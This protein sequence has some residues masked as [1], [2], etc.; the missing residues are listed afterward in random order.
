MTRCSDS[1]HL[2]VQRDLG[3]QL[4]TPVE[5]HYTFSVR[6]LGT[7][8]I[9]VTGSSG[10]IG[11]AVAEHFLSRGSSVIGI[12]SDARSDFFGDA[13]STTHNTQRLLSQW[14]RFTHIPVDI[15]DYAS[16]QAVVDFWRPCAVI[17]SA[18]QPSHDL[19]AR[20][21]FVDFDINAR[22]TLN[23]LETARRFVPESPFIFLSTNKV[24]GTKPNDLPFVEEETRWEFADSHL[25]RG[26]DE[27]LGL[28]Q[29][30]HSLFGTSKAAADLMVQE[31]GRYFSMPTVVLRGGCLTGPHH[32]GAELHGFLSYLA[33]CT[34]NGDNYTVFGYKGKQVRDNIDARD[35]ASLIEIMLSDPKSGEVYNLGGGFSN[36]IS[37]LEAIRAFEAESA[38]HLRWEYSDIERK[39]DHR[40]YYT[41]LSK[42]TSHYPDWTIEWPLAS[43]VVE[44]V[45][46]WK[47]R[48]GV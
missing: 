43:I 20:I 2:T 12:D 28:D 19:A 38:H 9:L 30:L 21:P 35:V 42:L 45:A 41:D 3:G 22:G 16:L 7:Q 36:S 27:E 4:K 24:Y 15:R 34:V 14:D 33:K 46:A 25:H 48:L 18:A 37:V 17:H 13:A 29:T 8:P 32:A 23:M 39:G 40:V 1:L 11:S 47:S 44:L 10:L 26:L 31:Y 5:S 6:S